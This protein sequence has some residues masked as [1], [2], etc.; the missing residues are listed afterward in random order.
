MLSND[1][2]IINSTFTIFI[3]ITSLIIS[4][5]TIL[6][7]YH[8][9][10]FYSINNLLLCNSSFATI[11]YFLI[12]IFGS[13]S[14]FHKDWILPSTLCSFRAYCL[15]I[16]I[17]ALSYSKSLDAISRLLSTV[18]Y[19]HR[20][21][22][23]YRA[24]RIY[25][26]LTWIICII[27]CIS[28]FFIDGGYAY[29]NESPL[30]ISMVSCLIPFCIIAFVYIAILIHVQR[31]SRR[32]EVSMNRNILQT[33]KREM[34]V[35]RKMLIQIN[36]L[37]AGGQTFLFLIIWH[38]ITKRSAPEPLYPLCLTSIT[39]V[40]SVVP[41]IQII[42]NKKLKQFI[43]Q[44]IYRHQTFL[45]GIHFNGGTIR[46]EPINP[47]LNS[48]SIPISIIQTYSWTYPTISCAT[49]VPISTP[50]RSG[51]NTSL[52]CVTD[53]TTDGGYS[54]NPVDIL[55]D[56]QT[57]NT[58]LGMMTSQRSVNINLT[59]DAHF[60]LAYVGSAWLPLNNPT[61][62]GLEWSIVC[63]ID[64]RMRPDGII[65]T[66]PVA[67]VV[68]PQY[69]IVN[70]TTQI[71][72][73][74]SDVNA[75][76][77]VRCRW[78]IY[79]S[80]SRRRRR[81]SINEDE[82][83]NQTYQI[84]TSS[85]SIKDSET[86][87][88]RVR[89]QYYNC[90]NCYSTCAYNCPCSCY[91]CMGT[92]CSGSQC[93]SASG[94]SV[95]TTTVG[96]TTVET[97]GTLKSTS[98]YSNRQP[99]DE[100]GGICF[101]NSLPTGTTLSGCTITFTGLVPNTWYGVSVQVEDFIN[102]T[103][104]TSMSSVPVQFLI[105]VQPQP[106]CGLKPIILPLT[107]CLDVQVGVSTSFDYQHIS[108]MNASNL[109]TSS[110]NASISYITFTWIP[111]INQVG[112]QKLCVIASTEE[113]LSSSI[114]CVTFNV[115]SSG[116]PCVTTTTTTTSTTTTTTTTSTTTTTTSTTST[117]TTTSST[118]TTTT[119]TS[120]TTTTT[121]TTTTTTTSTTTT[122]T[123]MTT[124]ISPKQ[125]INWPLIVGLSLL[126]LLLSLCF[127]CCCLYWLLL[128][129]G[130]RR[131]R[132]QRNQENNAEKDTFI[133]EVVLKKCPFLRRIF[134]IKK[135]NNNDSNYDLLK[136]NYSVGNISPTDLRL[137]TASPPI[138]Q[139]KNINNRSSI[140]QQDESVLVKEEILQSLTEFNDPPRTS[141][142]VQITRVPRRSTTTR[143]QPSMYL[144]P[145]L[146]T[147]K[148]DHRK[149]A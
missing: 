20:Y 138:I 125:S 86:V 103:S 112:S 69:A 63:F 7:I 13:I 127:C 146:I 54:A 28:P 59:A 89:R 115:I 62:N 143:K 90:W 6:I 142:A 8:N 9:H 5:L 102:S 51:S 147:R 129:P 74:V 145:K 106:T 10:Q 83:N 67:S 117:T 108:G 30:Y 88:I 4:L 130:S 101:P 75:G 84:K 61:E 25:I 133:P 23:T 144:I 136:M 56:C 113:K 121:S 46:W 21:L 124:T 114:Y 15:N 16:A 24:H 12:S 14:A 141:N 66:P 53:C 148:V 134:H 70:Q 18:F 47:T 72:I 1:F 132:R 11:F 44:Y 55:T 111:Q 123:T 26:L 32:V 27:I 78:S 87:H 57:V 85:K 73:P 77:D 52:M 36:I 119:T 128:A 95:G 91:S 38:M 19:K 71:T 118:T 94:C 37:F 48:S 98:S 122:I 35:V 76:D 68:S 105:Y 43:R 96:T 34:K 65:N 50:G 131:R 22:L 2:Y 82:Y 79:N 104:N 58:A 120:T 80:G 135:K 137:T 45:D 42:V 93:N 107:G 110:I 17:A 31:S 40:I 139:Q 64:L 3:S 29:E 100:C 92:T 149:V 99:I 41:I 49:D 109:I 116:I 33:S 81:R 39:L 97:P 140:I 126:A 60:Y